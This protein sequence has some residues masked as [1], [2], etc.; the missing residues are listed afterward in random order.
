MKRRTFLKSTL[1][2]P[3]LS[4]RVLGANEDLRIGAIGI[5]ST[6]KIGGKGKGDI[7][8][9]RSMPSDKSIP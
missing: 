7:R 5:G 9:F 2:L 6:V 8:A 3:L 1:A 4:R